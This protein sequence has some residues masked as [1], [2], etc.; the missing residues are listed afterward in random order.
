MK[1]TLYTGYGLPDVVQIKDIEKPVPKDNE[2]LPRKPKL[3]LE[4]T[5]DGG[6]A[7]T[8]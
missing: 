5:R 7:Y 4:G 6:D 3:Q 8:E 1:A 2:V